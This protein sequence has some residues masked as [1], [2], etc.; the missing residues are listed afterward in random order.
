M[1]GGYIGN[2]EQDQ[3]PHIPEGKWNHDARPPV[4]EVM[5]WNEV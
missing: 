1:V 5:T 2:R 4:H 3:K